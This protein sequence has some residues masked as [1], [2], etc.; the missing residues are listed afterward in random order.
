MTDIN[1]GHDFAAIQKT[2]A[3]GRFDDALDDLKQILQDDADNPDARYMAAVCYRYT[4]E[5]DQAQQL[6]DTLKNISPDKGRVYQEQ[7][8]LYKAQQ[9]NS[10]ALAAYRSACQLNP[11]LTA[12]WKA[13]AELAASAADIA[14]ARAQLQ[15]LQAL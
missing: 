11:A 3:A 2:I 10:Q 12:S 6:L 15:R 8:H 14:Q 7:G 4:R 1:P 13:Q 9:Y 5:F